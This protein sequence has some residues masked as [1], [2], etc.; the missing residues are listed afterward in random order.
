MIGS[1]QTW[2][3]YGF[4]SEGISVDFA[5]YLYGHGIGNHF[6]A[7]LLAD[8]LIDLADKFV[9]VLFIVCILKFLPEQ[10]KETYDLEGWQQ[11]PL[12]S[13]DR[14]AVEESQCRFVSLRTKILLILTIASMSIAIAATAISM[15]LFK[16]SV[17]EESTYLAN[18]IAGLASSVIDAERIG[19][20]IKQG[21][22]AEGYLETEKNLY[23]IKDSSPD[24]QYVYVYK[25]MQD[26]C[27]VV[28]D[29]DTDDTPGSEPGT[30]I[31]FDDAFKS[32]LPRL[33]AGKTIDPII[34]NESYG[35]LLT[36]YQP[37]YDKNGACV[38][39]AAVDVSMNQLTEKQYS[40]L[41]KL[42][43]L[44]LGFFIMI[45]A[46]GWWLAKYNLVL[47]INTIA[48]RASAFA[49][50]SD[51]ARENSVERIRDLDI[52]T[53]DEVENLYHA[54]L[55][56]TE[57]S[58]TYVADIQKKTETISQMQDALILV[59]ADMVESRDKCTGDHVR[60][61]AAYTKIIMNELRKKGGTDEVH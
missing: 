19:E 21:E 57:D 41:T 20:Y 5:K 15:V 56:T 34:S 3:L 12:S 27:H 53:G 49:Y 13:E 10:L 48:L 58:M 44:F 39:Y 29:L 30:V 50:D 42:I 26:G 4:A 47:P 16:D 14:K 33:F 22:K 60:K 40:F 1:V 51:E 37:V 45:L 36:V 18:G 59:L 28:F 38:C 25:I 61:T 2:F 32:Y 6:F 23:S 8:Y 52:H 46:I 43:S 7:Q 9:T 17:I 31:P 24:I 11:T 55:K 54:F 35:W